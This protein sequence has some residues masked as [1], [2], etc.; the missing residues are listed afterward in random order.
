MSTSNSKLILDTVESLLIED[1]FMLASDTATKARKICVLLHDWMKLPENAA[2]LDVF[3]EQLI[4]TLTTC[5]PSSGSAKRRREKMWV[6][7]HQTRLSQSFKQMWVAFVTTAIAVQPISLLFPHI[8]D[9]VF[10]A[11]ITKELDV[12]DKSTNISL[13]ITYEEANALRYVAG[14]VCSKVR[15]RI[16][17]SKHPLR[18]EMILYE[19][20][21]CMMDLCDDDDKD[22]D[23]CRTDC[24]NTVDRVGPCRISEGTY[25]FF[26]EMDSILRSVYTT[27]NAKSGEQGSKDT[28]IKTVIDSDDVK[29]QWCMVTTEVEEKEATGLLNMIVTC[30]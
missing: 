21:P 6:A 7:F 22:G 1:G 2:T 20:L 11:I 29:F 25:M 24:V 23:T 27:D 9:K 8:T 3:A 16:T 30:M 10:Q 18:D 26:H 19:M 15:K 5:L 17:A 28:L 12:P 4:T 14:Y 13:M